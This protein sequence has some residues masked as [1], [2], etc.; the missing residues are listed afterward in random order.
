MVKKQE[1]TELEQKLREM[2]K[3]SKCKTENKRIPKKFNNILKHNYMLLYCY[4][5]FLNH[6]FRGLIFVIDKTKNW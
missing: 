5:F 4:V 1:L 6:Y 3:G 2:E